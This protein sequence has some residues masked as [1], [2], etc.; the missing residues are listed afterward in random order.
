ML[1][2]EARAQGHEAVMIDAKQM[3]LST[4]SRPED[5]GLGGGA[6]VVLERCVSYIRGLH[7]TAA[8]ESMG[9]EVI[10]CLD[11]ATVCGNKMLM[12]L[13][14]SEAGVPTPETHF[15]FTREAASE[16]ARAEGLPLVIKPVIGSWGRGVMPVRDLDTLDAVAEMRELSDTPHDRVYYL[17]RLVDRPPRD[18][19]VVAVGGR[20]V[21]AE[22]REAGSGAFA[23]NVSAGGEPKP[24]EI[25]GEMAGLAEHAS[26]AVGGGVL[27][28]DMMEDLSQ[29]GRL[30]VHE[31]NNTVEFKGI[32]TVTGANIPAEIVKYAA[33]QTVR[34][35]PPRMPF[36]AHE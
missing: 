23:T 30:V 21:A 2:D 26:A 4:Q 25:T 24:C 3:R 29:G 8:L 16:C 15:A 20:A 1:R 9:V 35:E 10:N 6:V 32:S 7:A 5:L 13:R 11:T 34:C 22:Y 12:T 36:G 31:V 33:M 28:I 14:L 19:R 27:G 18:I 17:Q